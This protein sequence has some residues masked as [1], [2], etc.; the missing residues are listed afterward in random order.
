MLGLPADEYVSRR[1]S[2]KPFDHVD[3]KLLGGPLQFLLDK[4]A[5]IGTRTGATEQT[6]ER[7]MRQLRRLGVDHVKEGGLG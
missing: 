5:R 2:S 1:W 6:R 3:E 4:Q 7:A